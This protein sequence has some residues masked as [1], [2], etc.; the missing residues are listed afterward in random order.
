[1][2]EINFLFL[3]LIIKKKLFL[4]ISTNFSPNNFRFSFSYLYFKII[5]FIP[6]KDKDKKDSILSIF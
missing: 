1:M 3:L 4:L 2:C 6:D 5:S